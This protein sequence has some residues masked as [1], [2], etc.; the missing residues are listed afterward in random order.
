[1]SA[2]ADR[3]LWTRYLLGLLGEQEREMAEERFFLDEAAFKELEEAENELIARYVQGSLAERD[4]FE[5]NYLITDE[6]RRRVAAERA[7]GAHFAA[8]RARARRMVPRFNSVR[9]WLLRLFAAPGAWHLAGAVAA[10]VIIAGNVWLVRDWVRLRSQPAPVAEIPRPP[11]PPAPAPVPK[12]VK[13]PVLVAEDFGWT[14]NAVHSRGTDEEIPMSVRSDTPVVC[15]VV[16]ANPGTAST[17]YRAALLE[18]DRPRWGA[19]GLTAASSRG[20][21]VLV[22]L[23][24]RALLRPGSV[25]RLLWQEEGST[26]APES[27]VLRIVEETQ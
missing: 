27:Q 6:R 13:E 1:M 10:L 17:R 7:L 4:A 18:G 16:A 11:V 24:P 9:V 8:E 21:R 23:V 25:Y 26:A 20:K 2:P 19:H 12:P 15:L 5:R 3:T 22:F 14:R